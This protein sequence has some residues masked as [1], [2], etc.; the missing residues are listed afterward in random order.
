VA[1][2]SDT[3]P[4]ARRR[5][6]VGELPGRREILEVLRDPLGSEEHARTV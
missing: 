3:R 5:G 4:V 2:R 1:R 6:K